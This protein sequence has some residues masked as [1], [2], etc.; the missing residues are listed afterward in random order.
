[1]ELLGKDAVMDSEDVRQQQLQSV[2]TK[3]PKMTAKRI[4]VEVL[5]SHVASNT[6]NVVP[7]SVVQT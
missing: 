2:E 3:T 4:R 1:M 5:T 6:K 7:G